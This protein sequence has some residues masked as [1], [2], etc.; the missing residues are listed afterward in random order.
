MGTTWFKALLSHGTDG[1]PVPRPQNLIRVRG[2][3]G[4]STSDYNQKVLLKG[5]EFESDGRECPRG[6]NELAFDWGALP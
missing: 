6:G 2:G 1:N 5:K 3:F 4:P